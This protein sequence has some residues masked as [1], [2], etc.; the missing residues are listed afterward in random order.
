LLSD[1]SLFNGI[2][3]REKQCFQPKATVFDLVTDKK[4]S[5]NLTFNY[6]EDKK[7]NNYVTNEGY[8]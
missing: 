6:T 2:F 1:K 8:K 3:F 4:T 5:L 7:K